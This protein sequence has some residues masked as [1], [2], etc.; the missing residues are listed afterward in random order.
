MFWLFRRGEHWELAS[1]NE[2][3]LVNAPALF[4][5]DNDRSQSASLILS[6]EDREST[7][8]PNAVGDCPGM[9]PGSKECTRELA[10]SF[11]AMQING[12]AARGLERNARECVRRGIE[13]V[14]SSFVAC[15]DLP[16]NERLALYARGS[17]ESDVGRRISRDRFRHAADI[18]KK[19]LE[20]RGKP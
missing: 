10:T 5:H 1:A 17:C 8:T 6:I 11:C 19:I 14:R 3:A 20:L 7:L 4:D 2:W 16:A 9:R 12:P 13:M 15:R 18:R